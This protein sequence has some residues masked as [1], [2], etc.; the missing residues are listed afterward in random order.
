MS[1]NRS[2]E[3]NNAHDYIDEFK[4]RYAKAALKATDMQTIRQTSLANL[5]RWEEK[6]VWCSANDEW[7]ELMADG[8]DEAIIAAMTGRD[9]NANRLRQSSPYAG[10]VDDVT[11]AYL[12]ETRKIE[13]DAEATSTYP[14]V[15]AQKLLLAK[16][17]LSKFDA[18]VIRQKSLSF[19]ER[20]QGVA[21]SLSAT[22]QEWHTLLTS[23]SDD[24]IIAVMTGSDKRDVRLR[25]VHP[26]FDL[27]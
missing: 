2:S 1:Y 22:H 12:L 25:L 23:G 15:D 27:L 20:L 21:G 17:L 6:G 7:R 8:T 18:T 4:L 9:E 16:N 10:I 19:L 26:F 3:M 5:D 14:T 11:R 13:G 24:E